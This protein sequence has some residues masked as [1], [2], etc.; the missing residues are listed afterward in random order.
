MRD[1]VEERDE[2]LAFFKD[3]WPHI[4][5]FA[6]DGSVDEVL[7]S[8]SPYAVMDLI[9]AA[10]SE[11]SPETRMKAKIALLHM[12]LGTP[13]Q[14]SITFS[15]NINSLPEAEL[16]ALLTSKLKALPSKTRKAL[17]QIIDE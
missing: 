6:G 10:R 14:R 12:C 5:Q 16:D 11:K 17:T 7:R 15:K 1:E 13:V 8:Y 3:V 4:K 2:A 9:V